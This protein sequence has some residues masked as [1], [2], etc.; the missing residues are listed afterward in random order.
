M[1]HLC[2]MVAASN[3]AAPAAKRQRK[4]RNS[5]AAWPL[6]RELAVQTLYLTDGMTPQK[7]AAALST[8][9]EP[10]TGSAVRGLIFRR[11][12][13]PQKRD[14]AQQA[15]T[16]A[17]AR[18]KEHVERVV[19]ATAAVAEAASVAGLQRALSATADTGK[20]AARDFRSWAGGA[21]D[22]VNVARQARGLVDPGKVTASDGDAR[23]INLAFFVGNVGAGVGGASV[24]PRN[25]TPITTPAAARDALCAGPITNAAPL[26]A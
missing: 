15:E 24:G 21:R 5:S 14:A 23:T 4:P 3:P 13:T 2:A 17:L 12:W 20:D 11:G 25:V 18:G 22:L 1:Q 6:V 10:L 16:L 9:A 8:P 7:I 26:Q 19:Q